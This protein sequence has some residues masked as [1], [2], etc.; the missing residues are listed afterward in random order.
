MR[1]E[2]L[3][4]CGGTC[5]GRRGDDQARE[6]RMSFIYGVCLRNFRAICGL[7][8]RVEGREGGREG[9]EIKRLCLTWWCVPP[10]HI[11]SLH[12]SLLTSYP[13]QLS[14]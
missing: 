3:Q 8:V 5:L 2:V 14:S 6:W 1:A 7:C 11:F 9:S 4:D 13:L 10:S 12:P